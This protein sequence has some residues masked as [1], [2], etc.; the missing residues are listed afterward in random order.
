MSNNGRKAP[1]AMVLVDGRLWGDFQMWALG[2][3]FSLTELDDDDPSGAEFQVGPREP[4]DDPRP[5]E[6]PHIKAR[7]A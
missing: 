2:R 6:A 1:P 5:D 4:V 7:W 3:G